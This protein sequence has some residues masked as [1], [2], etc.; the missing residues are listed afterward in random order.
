MLIKSP[1]GEFKF[2]SP[3]VRA[4]VANLADGPL[5]FAELPERPALKASPKAAAASGNRPTLSRTSPSH[6]CHCPR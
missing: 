6:R 5:T 1:A 2:D 4:V 3:L